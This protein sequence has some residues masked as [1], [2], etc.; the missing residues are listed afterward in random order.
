MNKL[1]LT[2]LGLLL[3]LMI[4]CEAV[5]PVLTQLVVKFGQDLIAAASVNHAPRYAVEMES[6]LLALAQQATGVQMQSQLA[7]IGY[8]PP[9]PKYQQQNNQGQYNQGQYN[10][11]QYGQDPYNQSQNDPYGQNNS[12]SNNPYGQSNNPYQQPGNPSGQS[13]NPYQQPNDPYG[14]SNDPYQQP[15]DPYG[16]AN[17]NNQQA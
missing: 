6:L 5:A 15:N 1:R 11:D 12:A 13:N 7:Q 14:Q 9:P 17:N 4:G 10:Q 8:Q 3:T 2:I 16:Q